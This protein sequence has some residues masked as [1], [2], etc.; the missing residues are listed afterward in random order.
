M[1]FIVK[2]AYNIKM[3][4]IAKLSKIHGGKP[5]SGLERGF[6]LLY[7]HL[8]R[9]IQDFYCESRLMWRSQKLKKNRN[10]RF[11]CD[12]EKADLNHFKNCSCKYFEN[13]RKIFQGKSSFTVHETTLPKHLLMCG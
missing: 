12:S 1:V 3:V 11:Y 7:I 9:Y 10:F 6:Q 8:I 2:V 4:K 13:S 5:N